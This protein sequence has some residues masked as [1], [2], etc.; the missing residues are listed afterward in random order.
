MPPIQ[1]KL[2]GV[3]MDVALGDPGSNL[4]RIQSHL[5]AAANRGA[6]LIV[7]PECAL[8][9]YCFDSLDEANSV[10]QSIPGPSTETLART[11]RDLQVHVIYGLLEKD[12]ERLFNACVLVGPDGLVAR[13]RK[14][15]LPYLGVDRFATPGDEPFGVH[16][17]GD[18]RIGMSICY[19]ASFPESARVLALAASGI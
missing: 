12:G 11:C 3:Q 16:A 7:F 1:I 18:V 4:Q 2:A 9:G 10:A 8:T 6:Q 15:H 19:D 13:Y 14:V 5:E 17:A